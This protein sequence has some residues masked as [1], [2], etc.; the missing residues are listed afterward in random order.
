MSITT[1]AIRTFVT[2]RLPAKA[3]AGEINRE[4]ACLM[5]MFT[6][7]HIP[8]LREDNVRGGFFEP[9]QFAAV[10]AQLPAPLQPVVTFAYLTG[11]RLT[12]EILP[13]EWR[14]V[15]W[16]GRTV[17]LD[18]GTTKN[19]EGP[20]LPPFTAALEAVLRAQ[21]AEHD[22]LKKTDRIVPLV[23]HRDGE[24]IK[25]LRGAWQAACKAAGVPGRILHDFRQTAVRNMERDGVS[26]SAAMA[27]VGHKTEAIYRRYAIVDAA[28]LR[29]AADQIDRAANTVF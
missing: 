29:Q 15:D 21:K 5:R 27:M 9:E 18:P 19:T 3:S 22:E 8:M 26:R 6:L 2:N 23:F 7:A 13:L 28:A 4:L 24:R 11:W 12:S 17:R 16:Q 10:K 1:P 14:Q 25:S 20:H